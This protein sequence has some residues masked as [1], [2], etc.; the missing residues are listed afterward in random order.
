MLTSAFIA[1]LTL[2]KPGGK[3]KYKNLNRKTNSG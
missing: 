3:Y 2:K 1:V